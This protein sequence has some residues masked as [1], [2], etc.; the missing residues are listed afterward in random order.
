MQ[1]L[2]EKISQ[3]FTDGIKFDS[4]GNAYPDRGEIESNLEKLFKE[5][6]SAELE[7]LINKHKAINLEVHGRKDCKSCSLLED[8]EQARKELGN[9]RP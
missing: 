9:E 4:E 7:T 3:I 6:F 1:S 2:K 8:L 5:A